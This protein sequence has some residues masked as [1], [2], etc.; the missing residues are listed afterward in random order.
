VGPLAEGLS[1]FG[2]HSRWS[3][4]AV[5]PVSMKNHSIQRMIIQSFIAQSGQTLQRIFGP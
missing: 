1:D 3:W 4:S 5:A 2:Y